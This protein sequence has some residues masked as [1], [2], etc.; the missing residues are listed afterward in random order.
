[1]QSEAE[2]S[3]YVH[4]MRD[5]GALFPIPLSITHAF[6]GTWKWGW[7]DAASEGNK[8]T[9]GMTW[10]GTDKTVNLAGGRLEFRC[11]H[12]NSLLGGLAIP[13]GLF[14]PSQSGTLLTLP[15]STGTSCRASLSLTLAEK[16]PSVEEKEA[17]KTTVEGTQVCARLAAHSLTPTPHNVLLAFP[18]SG[19]EIWTSESIL[20]ASPYFEALFKS[21]FAESVSTST[22]KK[23]KSPQKQKEA[24]ETSLSSFPDDSDDE[25]DSSPQ[26]TKPI[27]HAPPSFNYK[28]ITVTEAAF[29]T[30]L[31]V[32][33]FLQCQSIS[34]APLRSLSAPNQPQSTS[35]PKS[36]KRARHTTGPAQPSALPLPVSPKSVFRLAHFLTL[37]TL[38]DLALFDFRTQL[39]AQNATAELFSPFCALYPEARD[40]VLD[41]VAE[42]RTEVGE[43]EETKKRMEKLASEGEEEVSAAEAV[44]L[45]K[46]A[47]RLMEK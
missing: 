22:S 18:R 36:R 25:T 41:F 45:A 19:R 38:A 27:S 37:P 28:T 17:E 43:A 5:R 13:P 23:S 15:I 9:M 21:G 39:S 32:I 29:S 4:S 46:L 30:Y 26:L 6:G 3:L 16:V 31:A 11:S 14:P 2:I 47:T 10:S 34:F 35:K 40:A 24:V 1:M 42:H 33:C 7:V 8:H 20:C 44:M 12:M